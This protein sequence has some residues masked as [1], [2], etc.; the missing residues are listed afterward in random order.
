MENIPTTMDPPSF[1]AS[2]STN[3]EI[4]LTWTTPIAGVATGG[5]AVTID[6]YDL[7]YD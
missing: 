7:E 2:T 4:V 5:S 1:D 6:S 3:T